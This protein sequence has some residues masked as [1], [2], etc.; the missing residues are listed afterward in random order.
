[1][2]ILN[3]EDPAQNCRL[4][5]DRNDS[6]DKG[7]SIALSRGRPPAQALSSECSE[8]EHD[9]A[10]SIQR[11]RESSPAGWLR[12]DSHH[13]CIILEQPRMNLRLLRM[14]SFRKDAQMKSSHVEVKTQERDRPATS[15]L[16]L[17]M[18]SRQTR[19]IN[20]VFIVGATMPVCTPLIW[21]KRRM[22]GGNST[23]RH[24][25]AYRAAAPHLPFSSTRSSVCQ[26][27]QSRAADTELC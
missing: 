22:K 27:H 8:N 2:Q 3:T 25:G 1:M 18:T 7:S 23:K 10:Q 26:L 21:S 6:K 9:A 11:I 13:S 19:S 20:L 24:M 5:R 16:C 12:K 17:R 14:A 4:I 15:L